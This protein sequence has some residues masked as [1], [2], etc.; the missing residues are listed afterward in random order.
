MDKREQQRTAMKEL[1]EK[2]KKEEEAQEKR[3]VQH[4]K[5]NKKRRTPQK[6]RAY[7]TKNKIAERA[8]KDEDMKEKMIEGHR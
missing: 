5:H 6:R 1:R 7:K 3:R 8:R 4:A 2:R